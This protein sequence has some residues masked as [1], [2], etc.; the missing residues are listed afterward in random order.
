VQTFSL[1]VLASR[2]L[3]RDGDVFVRFQP[4]T[5]VPRRRNIEHLRA[6]PEMIDP[7]DFDIAPRLERRK[8]LPLIETERN[9]Q[10]LESHDISREKVAEIREENG[11]RRGD[12]SL[13]PERAYGFCAE[14]AHEPLPV[15]ETGEG[16]RK[17]IG[18]GDRPVWRRPK[19][20]KIG[21]ADFVLAGGARAEPSHPRLGRTTLSQRDPLSLARGMEAAWPRPDPGSG[22]SRGS[23]H[24]SPAG[25]AG[26]TGS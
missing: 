3:T 11:F 12:V 5:D 20:A 25:K 2:R 8:W 16:S 17:K 6:V 4:K 22:I 14:S 15:G 23:V 26:R 9:L 13:I 19:E 18:R 1:I 10:A 24:D 7:P 21:D